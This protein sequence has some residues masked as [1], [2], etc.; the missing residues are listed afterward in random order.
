MQDGGQLG[1]SSHLED[2][3]GGVEAEIQARK[4]QDKGTGQAA[5]I[6]RMLVE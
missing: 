4:S 2:R 5:W 3:V 6:L 1:A